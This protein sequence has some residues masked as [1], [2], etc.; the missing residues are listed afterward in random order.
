MRVR[1]QWPQPSVDFIYYCAEAANT[2]QSQSDTQ[3]YLEVCER[4]RLGDELPPLGD[5]DRDNDQE[6]SP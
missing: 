3:A 6:R 2:E 4:D 1:Q 5:T